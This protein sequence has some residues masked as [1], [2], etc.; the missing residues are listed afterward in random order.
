[1]KRRCKIAARAPD[2]IAH[3]RGPAGYHKDLRVDSGWIVGGRLTIVCDGTYFEKS[4]ASGG[5]DCQKSPRPFV[6][7]PEATMSTSNPPRAIFRFGAFEVDPRT[8]ELRKNGMRIR[9]QEQPI[10]VLVALLER[11]GELLTREELRQRVGPGDTFVDFDH[12]LTP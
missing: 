9:C 12:A 2:G 6:Q 4:D 11:P 7:N 10:Q 8:G 5:G 1:M 3:R